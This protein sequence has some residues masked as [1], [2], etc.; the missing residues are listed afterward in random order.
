[1]T[2][3]YA[4]SSSSTLLYLTPA[5]F[6]ILDKIRFTIEER[7]GLS[8]ILGDT[9]MGKSSILRYLN[10]EYSTQPGYITAWLPKGQF[11]SP[12]AMLKA[13]CY[14]L[15]IPAKRSFELQSEALNEYLIERN[16]A[17]ERVIMFV[18]ESQEL[19]TLL[20]GLLRTLLNFESDRGKLLQI[21]IA[22]QLDLLD[23]LRLKKNKALTSRIFAPCLVPTLVRQEVGAMIQFRCERTIH[24]NNF[25]DPD[26]VDQIYRLSAGIPRRIIMICSHAENL[27]KTLKSPITVEILQQADRASSLLEFETTVGAV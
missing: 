11:A 7:Q 21:V 15:S 19:S 13:I 5:L 10:E 2:S 8:C 12:F 3:P 17:G 24:P 20:L 16:L 14:D 9:G 25:T 27:S 22:G 23:R 18:D 26:L 6:T 1:M 4:I